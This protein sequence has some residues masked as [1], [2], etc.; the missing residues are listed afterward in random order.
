MAFRYTDLAMPALRK[1]HDTYWLTP[2]EE[3]DAFRLVKFYRQSV[4]RDRERA[5]KTNTSSATQHFY[6]ESLSRS[7]LGLADA[8]TKLAETKGRWVFGYKDKDV[9]VFD[10]ADREAKAERQ[11]HHPVH[12]V[13]LEALA[14]YW[15]ADEYYT[16]PDLR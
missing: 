2:E 5:D 11:K 10:P 7:Q 13:T 14:I 6:A 15:Y 3:S 9:A 8:E 12:L 4:S 1:S 16:T